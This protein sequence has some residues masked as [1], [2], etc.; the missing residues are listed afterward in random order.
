MMFVYQRADISMA[1][2]W[3]HNVSIVPGLSTY[4]SVEGA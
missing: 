2:P 4:N 1:Q 3:V